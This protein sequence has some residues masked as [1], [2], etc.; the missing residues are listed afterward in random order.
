MGKTLRCILQL[1]RDLCKIERLE[2]KLTTE[3]STQK[4]AEIGLFLRDM[5]KPIG[6]IM[7][8]VLLEANRTK[9]GHTSHNQMGHLHFRGEGHTTKTTLGSGD[10]NLH[11]FAIHGKHHNHIQDVLDWHRENNE[12]LSSFKSPAGWS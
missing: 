12:C 10:K 9:S 1:Q 8:E 3:I 6:S 11:K 4:L 7:I 5:S 2:D